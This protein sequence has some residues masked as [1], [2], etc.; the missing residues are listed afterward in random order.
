MNED[1]RISKKSL[2]WTAASVILAVLLNAFMGVVTVGAYREKVD[3]TIEQVEVLDKRV[4]RLEN[5]T[6]RA[7]DRIEMNVKFL[8]EKNGGRYVEPSK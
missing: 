5:T 8:V 2:Y 7:L 3:R 4:S 1:L 6:I